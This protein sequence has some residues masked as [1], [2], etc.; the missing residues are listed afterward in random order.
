MVCSRQHPNI[1]SLKRDLSDAVNSFLMEE[2]RAA[3]NVWQNR[4]KACVKAKG[5]HF[6]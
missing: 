5:C 4:F 2:V 3:E 6:E 1:G